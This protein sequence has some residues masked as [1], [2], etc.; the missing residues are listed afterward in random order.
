MG[1]R[2]FI[3]DR[4]LVSVFN[5][6]HCSLP[7][8][9]QDILPQPVYSNFASMITSVFGN[10]SN[11]EATVID[12]KHTVYAIGWLALNQSVSLDLYELSVL[13]LPV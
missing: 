13:I 5:I 6:L 3:G 9:F 4:G 7:D 1:S 10:H 12:V 2:L 11:G 8:I